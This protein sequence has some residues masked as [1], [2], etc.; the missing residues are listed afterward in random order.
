M[1]ETKGRR[2]PFNVD[3][4]LRN[5]GSML[6]LAVD[7]NQEP[8]QSG[9][10]KSMLYGS[11]GFP[12]RIEHPEIPG[13]WYSVTVGSESA[14]YAELKQQAR[15]IKAQLAAFRSKGKAS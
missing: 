4:S 7:L 9:T 8:R 5:D 1:S 11:T 2:E 13:L 15:D 6:L 12:V 14:E 10:G 3:A